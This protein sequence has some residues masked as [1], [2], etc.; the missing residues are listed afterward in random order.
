MEKEI[1]YSDSRTPEER[2]EDSK[3]KRKTTSYIKTIK[4]KITKEFREECG[5]E[6]GYVSSIFMSQGDTKAGKIIMPTEKLIE[7]TDRMGLYL[8]EALSRQEAET[9][10]EI[11]QVVLEDVP[12]K[13]QKRLVKFLN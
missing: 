10:K 9:K 13:Y 4:E 2:K 12:I 3:I 6:L 8:F 7:V 1:N 11:L 5:K